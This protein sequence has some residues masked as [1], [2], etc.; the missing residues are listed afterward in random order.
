VL[1][2]IFVPK[3]EEVIGGCRELDNEEFHNL[4]SSTNGVTIPKLWKM[5][6]EGGGENIGHGW[7]GKY[8][9]TKHILT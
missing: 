7:Q 8:M 3:T 6:L 2:E 4:Y 5:R 1:G 9:N